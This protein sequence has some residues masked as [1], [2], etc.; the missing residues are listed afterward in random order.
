MEFTVLFNFLIAT[1]IGGLVGLERE[2]NQKRTGRSFAGIRTYILVAF[3]GAVISYLSFDIAWYLILAGLFVLIAVTYYTSSFKG[4]KGVT[5]ELSLVAVYIISSMAMYNQYQKLA[6]IF[7]VLL[8]ILLSTKKL[9]HGFAQRTKP[10]IWYDALVFIFMIFVVLPLIPNKEYSFLGIQN[11]FNPYQ[12]WIMVILVSGIS[13]VGYFLSKVVGTSYGIGLSGVLGGLVSSTAVTESMAHDSKDNPKLLNAYIF[14]SI[15]ANVVLGLRVILES[16]IVDSSLLTI[17]IIP[18]LV[19]TAVGLI[20]MIRWSIVGKQNGSSNLELNSPLS[21]KP[22]LIF[23]LIYSF[24]VFLTKFML[25]LGFS[26]S[27]FIA[28]AF[29]AGSVN[30][31]AITL[32]MAS[33]YANG[34]MSASVVWFSIIAAIFSNTLFKIV[35]SRIFG[36]KD[37]FWKY[38]ISMLIIILVGMI[39]LGLSLFFAFV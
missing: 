31:D 24:V 34:D 13:F 26:S 27:G 35:L 5:T 32:S 18:I 10:Q 11:C 2:I 37:F 12:T 38:T 30:L 14:A 6:I 22:A 9:L 36:S 39:S 8:A 28:V 4:F 1:A 33:L 15:S 21:L 16:W 25:S 20:I 23:G 3:L 17:G 19:M 29:F 7:G